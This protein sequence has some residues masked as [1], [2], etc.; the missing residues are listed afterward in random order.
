LRLPVPILMMVAVGLEWLGVLVKRGVPLSRYRVR[1]L[2]PLTGFDIS[3][4][5]RLLGWRPRVGV[6]EGLR[7]TFSTQRK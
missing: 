2:R 1:S 5:E 6:Q 4:A 7:R 3:R